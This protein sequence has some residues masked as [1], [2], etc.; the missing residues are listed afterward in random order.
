MLRI[1]D[2]HKNK[3]GRLRRQLATLVAFVF[4]RYAAAR[5]W[6]E[7]HCCPAP[8]AQDATLRAA[9]LAKD[10]GARATRTHSSF[11]RLRRP[12]ALH[13]PGR[14]AALKRGICA[15][16]AQRQQARLSGKRSYYARTRTRTFLHA[17]AYT[18]CS[19]HDRGGYSR[20]LRSHALLVRALCV[21]PPRIVTA[22]RASRASGAV[23]KVRFAPRAK[24]TA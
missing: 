10:G 9:G 6:T 8:S 19:L 5:P 2:A 17:H 23:H 12:F 24:P 18:T 13:A 1:D 3:S 16:R 15:R 4:V 22:L 11:A 21:V 20:G 14:R 7:R